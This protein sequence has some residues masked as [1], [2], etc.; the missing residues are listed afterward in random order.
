[1]TR[2][3]LPVTAALVTAAALLLTA[4]GGDS[5]SDSPDGIK[6]AA[7]AKTSPSAAASQIT[8]AK[9]P[10]LETSKDF[11]T[12]FEGW[13]NPDPKLQ[14]VL[15]DGK[16]RTLGIQSA[17]FKQD[18]S[19]PELAF[20]N[21]GTA[22]DGAKSWVSGYKKNKLTLTGTVRYYNPQVSISDSGSA[23]LFYCS[24]ESKSFDKDRRTEKVNVTP[25]T[26]SS[27]VLY[28]TKLRKNDDGIWQTVTLSGTRG[29]CK[30]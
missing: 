22:L 29:A 3:T 19:A 12:E 2:T 28:Q 24:D 21:T 25:V 16:N 15:D 27:Y 11:K 6:G 26:K 13:S 5:G 7:S 1:M 30:P 23:I 10:T 18:P 9:R 4:C 14:T 8:E 20:Y 17:I